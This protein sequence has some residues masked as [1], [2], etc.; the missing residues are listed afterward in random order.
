MVSDLLHS[1]AYNLRGH[2]AGDLHFADFQWK[3]K[4]HGAGHSLLVSHKTRHHVFRFTFHGRQG[5]VSK[6]RGSNLLGGISRAK[7][8]TAGDGR[9]SNH[10][11]GH[12]FSV[13]KVRVPGGGFQRMAYGMAKVE[14]ATQ[15]RFLL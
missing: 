2:I 6:S 10:A 5:A 15:I 4:M 7:T 3:N 11:P 9:S 1:A 14:N 13:E 12:G 8:G